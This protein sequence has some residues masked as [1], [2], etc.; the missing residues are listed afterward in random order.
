M[1]ICFTSDLHGDVALFAQLDE[2][3]R[4][5]RPDVLV[6]GGDMLVDV[7]PVRPLAPQI[8]AL[9]REFMARVEGWRGACPRM[10]IVLVA[11]N[12]E[13]AAYWRLLC[14]DAE[15]GRVHLLGHEQAWKYDGLTW[16]GF[17]YSPPTTHWAKDFERLD[18]PGDRLP[19]SPGYACDATGE[20]LCPVDI[21]EHFGRQPALS[22]EL[23]RITVPADPWILVAHVPPHASQLDRRPRLSYPVGS[24]A[25]RAFIE[26]RQPLLALHGHVHDAAEVTGTWQDRLGRTLCVNPGQSRARLHAVLLDPADPVR[27]LRHTVRP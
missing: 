21:P 15:A 2:L 8:R 18:L 25:V 1:R 4:A 14:A 13:L 11:G 16:L 9:H 3:L 10:P 24:R 22:D 23:N 17:G 5:E 6:L 26:A 19:R 20:C 7:N 12:H 27:S